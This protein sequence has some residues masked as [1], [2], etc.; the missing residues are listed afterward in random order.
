MKKSILK[1]TK[2]ILLMTFLFHSNVFSSIVQTTPK[3]PEDFEKIYGNLKQLSIGKNEVWGTNKHNKAFKCN[4]NK[5]EFTRVKGTL[6][7]VS[8]GYDDVIYGFNKRGKLHK[9]SKKYDKWIKVNLR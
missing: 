7:Q 4:I 3:F 1:I 5:K 2:Y 9:Y 6:K 8:V